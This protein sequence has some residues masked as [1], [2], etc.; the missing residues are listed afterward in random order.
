MAS[1]SADES[2]ITLTWTEESGVDYYLA[3][4]GTELTD[5]NDEPLKVNNGYKYA[6]DK[7]V[8]NYTFNLRSERSYSDGTKKEGTSNAAAVS[9]GGGES[10]ELGDYESNPAEFVQYISNGTTF[11]KLFFSA[12]E[13]RKNAEGEVIETGAIEKYVVIDADTNAELAE[14][15]AGDTL[16]YEENFSSISDT[17][18]VKIQAYK[19][20][21]GSDYRASTTPKA[22]VITPRCLSLIHISE[23]T[24]PY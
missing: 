20:V 13:P 4:N 15:N 18:S 16:V 19:T 24:R 6:V 12:P 5:T 21:N 10:G 8:T 9:I 7:A 14:I 17:R 3:V 11:V 2:D 1:L 23:P 22:A